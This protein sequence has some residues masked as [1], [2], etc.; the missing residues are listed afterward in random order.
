MQG[1]STEKH[2]AV[3]EVVHWLRRRGFVVEAG[4]RH[5]KPFNRDVWLDGDCIIYAPEAHPG[6]M[7]HEAGHLAVLP[8]CIRLAVRPGNIEDFTEPAITEYMES[9]PNAFDCPE[10]P[11]ARA[12]MQAGDTEAIAWAYAAAIDAQVDPWLTC[13]NGFGDAES[14]ESTFTGLK[15]GC[16]LGINGLRTA[17]FMDSTKD[18]PKLKFWKQP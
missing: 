18:F 17:G 4:R 11:V 3:R 8:S 2:S 7:L 6:D 9:H 5:V 16:Y 1:A 10:D 12:C 14:A 13:Q 15:A